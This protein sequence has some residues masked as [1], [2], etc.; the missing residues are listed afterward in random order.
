VEGNKTKEFVVILNENAKRVTDRVRSSAEKLAPRIALYTSRTKEEAFHIVREALDRGCQRIISGGGDGTFSHLLSAAKRCLEERNAQL[1]K[2]GRQAREGLSRLSLPEF[3]V[4]KLG[5]GNSLA[6]LLGLRKGLDPVRSLAGGLD[7][8]TLRIHLIEAEDRCCTFSGLGWDA[9]ILNDY[10]W[11]KER[12]RHPVLASWGRSIGGYLAAILLRTIP[13][14]IFRQRPVE[15]MARTLGSRL[16]RIRQDGSIQFVDAAAGKAFYEGPCNLVCVGTTPYYGYR[17][18]AFPYAMAL[19]GLMHV[20]I[21][22]A[23]VSEILAHVPAIWQGRYR[24]PNILDFLAERVDFSFSDAL[25]LQIG[26]DAEGYRSEI[27]YQVSPLTVDVLDF[28]RPVHT[29]AA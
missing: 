28:S 2:M 29:P 17:I 27:T 7:F 20:R 18:K 24:S 9:Q 5:T 25:P 15:A 4:L 6:P 26:G 22:K 14:V 1:Q 19:P 23:P 3:G 16:Y 12:I 13:T 21:V 10:V 8:E 11:L